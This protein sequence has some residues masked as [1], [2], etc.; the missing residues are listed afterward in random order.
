MEQVNVKYM[1]FKILYGKKYMIYSNNEKDFFFLKTIFHYVF[2]F[3]YVYSHICVDTDRGQRR[4]LE[5]LEL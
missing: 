4:A 1:W 2:V 5:S 3:V